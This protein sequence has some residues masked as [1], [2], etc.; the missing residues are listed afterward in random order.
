M[1]GVATAILIFI[2]IVGM[3][4]TLVVLRPRLQK[5]QEEQLE[6]L[7][8]SRLGRLAA[9]LQLYLERTD[10]LLPPPDHWCDALEEFIPPSQRRFV[11]HC[12]KLE[13]RGGYGYAMNAYAWDEEHQTPRWHPEM[14]PQSKVVLI[15]ET[16]QSRRNAVGKGDDIPVTGRHDGKILL[17]F[18]DGS[19]MAV[20]PDELRAMR[21]QGEV[22][23]KPLPPP[24]PS[25][26]SR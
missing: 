5:Q 8:A 6:R 3:S 14:Y 13:G 24:L 4:V 12:L 7:C 16:R 11:F 18:A 21:E 19:T 23:F 15:Y 17:L 10:N 1:R 20:T 25:F 9:A 22:L 2:V 26:P